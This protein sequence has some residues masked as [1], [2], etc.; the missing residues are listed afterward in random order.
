MPIRPTLII[1]GGAGTLSASSITADQEAAYRNALESCLG[2]GFKCLEKTGSSLEAVA[3]AVR[4]LEENPL[5]NA[6][7]GAVFTAKGN[8]QLDASIMDGRERKAGA[9]AGIEKTRNPV[10]AAKAVMERT[11]HV[12]LCGADADNFSRHIGLEQVPNEWFS[13]EFRKQQWDQV[14]GTSVTALDHSL[15]VGAN[16]KG[17]VGAAAYDSSGNLAAATSTGG[18]TNKQWGRVGDSPIV[19][20]GVWA[21]N[22]TCALS[23][24]GHG[25]FFIKYMA[26]YDVHCLMEYKGLS[27]EAALNK[28]V[29][30]KLH[31]VAPESGGLIG[32]SRLGETLACFN[33]EGM[34]RAWVSYLPDG[35]PKFNTAIYR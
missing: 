15:S 27:F 20:A 16:K 3:V 4:A 17:T 8:H 28:V 23:A 34:Y 32:V 18:M 35:S 30:E 5:F 12:F 11:E 33:S 31:H 9:V 22:T 2:E 25:E 1:H 19:G 6:G 29:M 13:T 21:D 14:K 10:L 24:T 7:K 26:C